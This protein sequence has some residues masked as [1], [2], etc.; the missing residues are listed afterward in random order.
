MLIN[1]KEFSD[2]AT[3]KIVLMGSAAVGK[4]QLINRI[5]N[6]NFSGVYDPTMDVTYLR[7][8]NF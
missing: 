2:L 7:K 8:S 5:V 6:N 1:E 3:L 4:T